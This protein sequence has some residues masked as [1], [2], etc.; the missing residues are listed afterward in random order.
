MRNIKYLTHCY[1]QAN[2]ITVK[3]SNIGTIVSQSDPLLVVMNG[4]INDDLAKFLIN[5]HAFA[6]CKTDDKISKY[7][8]IVEFAHFIID[9][10]QYSLIRK[11][12]IIF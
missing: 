7:P 12:R 9:N 1:L 5:S 6:L 4:H 11:V 8:E 3:E 10:V 2:I